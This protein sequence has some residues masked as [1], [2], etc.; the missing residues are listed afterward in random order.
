M[1][2]LISEINQWDRVGG[3]NIQFYAIDEEVDIVLTHHLPAKY[4]PYFL[5]GS[6]GIKKD[7]GEYVWKPYSHP[8]TDFID[9]RK[10][11]YW[12]FFIQS[13]ILTPDLLLPTENNGYG[14]MSFNGLIN[15]QHGSIR[16]GRWDDSSF[17]TVDRVV[18]KVTQELVEHKEY[19]AIYNALKRGFKKILYYPTISTD[20][21]GRQYKQ[22]N[23]MMSKAFA[24]KYLKGE[25][26]ASA[27]PDLEAA[28][29]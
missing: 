13:V 10:R 4:A 28:G 3:R 16:N 20:L 15:L 9:L 7:N 14:V 17:A 25:I 24:E 23:I 12:Y 26:K 22:K 29:H 8:V 1:A 11:G 2:K 19:L 6:E 5:I 21:L 18:N 27:A